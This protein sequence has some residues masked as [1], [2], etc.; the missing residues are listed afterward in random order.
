MSEKKLLYYKNQ[1]PP[2]LDEVFT[3]PLFPP[4]DNSLF[5]LDSSGNPIDNE[6]HKEKAEK[7]K[8]LKEKDIGFFR[9]KDILG[10]DYSLF[11]EQIEI[12]DVIQGSIGDCYF[13][14]AVANLSK[15]P[16]KVK[17]MFKQSEKNEKGFYE[18]EVFID[19]KKQI[20]IVDDYIPAYKSNKNIYF[21]RSKKRK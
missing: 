14:T 11:S 20:I 12:N 2:K 17:Q 10:N 7:I 19:G 1:E 6:V 18:I 16:N 8:E 4:T 5:G 13:M 15:Y 21:A 3:D 9:A